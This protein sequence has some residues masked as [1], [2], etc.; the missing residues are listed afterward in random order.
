M[1]V[2]HHHGNSLIGILTRLTKLVAIVSC[3]GYYI[4]TSITIYIDLLLVLVISDLQLHGFES[5]GTWFETERY[6]GIGLGTYYIV[7]HYRH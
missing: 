1:K 6:W 4:I 2:H 3:L 5:T 7:S